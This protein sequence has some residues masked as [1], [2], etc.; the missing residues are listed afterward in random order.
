MSQSLLLVTSD[1]QLA[2][3]QTKT[4]RGTWGEMVHGVSLDSYVSNRFTAARCHALDSD[5]IGF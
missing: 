2:C 1:T 5:L 3:A 4:H